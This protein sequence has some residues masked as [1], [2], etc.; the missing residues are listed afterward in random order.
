MEMVESS[1]TKQITKKVTTRTEIM[2]GGT[3]FD[4]QQPQEVADVEELL[5]QWE[6]KMKKMMKISIAE[7][8]AKMIT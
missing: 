3:D 4:Q 6:V 2:K 8:I 1:H 7:G 5:K